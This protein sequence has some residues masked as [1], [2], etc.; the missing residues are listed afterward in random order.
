MIIIVTSL[1]LINLPFQ[2]YTSVMFL[3]S[4]KVRWMNRPCL[5]HWDEMTLYD[6]WH[7]CNGNR[8]RWL[9]TVLLH[10]S[11]SSMREHSSLK[12][13]LIITECFLLSYFYKFIDF[14][15]LIFDN[16]PISNTTIHI[17]EYLVYNYLCLKYSE[18]Q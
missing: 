12:L 10:L 1:E 15:S 8:E 4:E 16:L 5:L 6:R 7:G 9:N 2:T 13:S 18:E 3:R 11:V 17:V 14:V